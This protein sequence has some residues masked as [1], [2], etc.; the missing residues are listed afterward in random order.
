MMKKNFKEYTLA[1]WDHEIG[2]ENLYKIAKEY[3]LKFNDMKINNQGIL[4]YVEAG[5]GKTY[6]SASIANALL[7]KLVPVICVGT[8]ALTERI[9]QSKKNYGEEGIFTVLNALENADLLIIDD[10]GTE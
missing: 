10:L 4:I 1:N 9:S 7:D 2:N 3:I 6:F 5:N 8:I